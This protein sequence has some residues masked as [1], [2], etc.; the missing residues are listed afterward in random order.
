RSLRVLWADRDGNVWGG[1]NRGVVRLEGGRFQSSRVS[2]E[3]GGDFVRCLFED[4]EGDLWIGTNGG[5]VRWRN[6]IFTVFGKTQGF[7][8]DRPNIVYQDH[9]GRVWIG[10]SDAGLMLFSGAPRRTYSTAQGLPDTQIM[11]IRETP[12]GDLLV[13]T[14]RGVARISGSTIR[15]Y[16]VPDPLSRGGV[17][18]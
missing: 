18:D 4:R 12:K 15:T 1:T 6:D 17:F 7:P 5:L 8:S 2:A 9:A 3:G 14:R 11:Q 13:C 16:Q 10:F